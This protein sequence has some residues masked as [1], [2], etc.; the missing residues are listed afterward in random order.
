M[1]GWSSGSCA[2]VRARRPSGWR[3]RPCLQDRV[4]R[5]VGA[6]ADVEAAVA[7]RLEA[8]ARRT[9]A[10]AA[11]CRGRRGSPARGA[12]GSPGSGRR[13]WRWP[14]RWRPPRAGC[15][16]WS[17]RHSADAS[18]ACARARWCAGRGTTAAQMRGDALALVEDLDGA[19][20]QARLDLLADEAVRH[21]VVVAL[22]VDVVVER[23]AAQAP[24]GVDVGLG[25]QA[26]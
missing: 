2:L 8:I 14:G 18:S 1:L 3:S 15:A 21:G 24:L 20:G 11:G 19:R 6:G 22:D 13:A 26:A 23:D 9:G 10:P 12:A 17:S 7:R 25:R 4:D 5:A 16:R